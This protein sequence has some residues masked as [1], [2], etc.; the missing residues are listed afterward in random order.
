MRHSKLSR[1]HR[2]TLIAMVGG[3]GH[4]VLADELAHIMRKRQHVTLALDTLQP[5][6]RTN[7][8]DAVQMPGFR[9]I[10]IYRLTMHG[11]NV[12]RQ[13]ARKRDIEQRALESAREHLAAAFPAGTAVSVIMV[14]GSPLAYPTADIA[15]DAEV[16]ATGRVV[17]AADGRS[18]SVLIDGNGTLV[19]GV[20]E[21]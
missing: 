5:I 15:E 16:I 3:D 17:D 14:D 13:L 12:A 9:R 7:G 19:P 18:V 8:R 6:T 20:I 4:A 11:A 21:R 1:K 2:D 10:R